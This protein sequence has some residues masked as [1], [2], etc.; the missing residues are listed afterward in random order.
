MR[1]P[2][3]LTWPWLL[4]HLACTTFLLIQLW[5]VLWN[6]YV[7]PSVTNTVVENKNLKDINFP[8][9]FKICKS[10]G[11]NINA[12]NEAGYDTIIDYFVGWS[13]Y[14]PPI[15]GWAGHTNTSGVQR[16]VVET[17]SKV[18]SHVMR[19]IIRRIDIQLVN[20]EWIRI[21]VSDA[22]LKRVNFPDNCY[23]LDITENPDVK[24]NG[25]WKMRLYFAKK[26]NSSVLITVAGDS[27]ACDRIIG[28]HGFYSTGDTIEK[29]NDGM[30]TEYLLEMKKNVFIEEDLTK[31]CRNYPSSDYASYRDCDDQYM[32]DYVAAR[33]P[34][35]VPIWL[36]DDM[37]NASTHYV[38]TEKKY[39]NYLFKGEYLSDCLLPCTTFRSESKFVGKFKFKGRSTW[40]NIRF[41]QTVQVT[42]TDFIKPTLST[43]LSDVGGSMGLWLGLGAVQALQMVINC[44]M[45]RLKKFRK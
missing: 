29:H 33:Q 9:V 27:L 25:I 10:P 2:L 40:M 20:L 21:N 7:K 43:F 14:N 19:E 24:E 4:V 1:L 31:E 8:L 13:K 39:L 15:H 23:T 42:T 5:L 12:L 32:K 38:S 41:S 17:F 6:G 36:T 3:G 22:T 35:L 30:I 16:S 37:E 11:F 28:V 18:R 44:V 45:L 34:G 26:L